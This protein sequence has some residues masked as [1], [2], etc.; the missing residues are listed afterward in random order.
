VTYEMPGKKADQKVKKVLLCEE[1]LKF[2][3][4]ATEPVINLLT[5]DQ[6]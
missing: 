5:K 2:C 3:A 4:D 6:K 1:T